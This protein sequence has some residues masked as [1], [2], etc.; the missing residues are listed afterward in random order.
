MRRT[1]APTTA[2]LIALATLSAP[3]SV[4][5]T[6]C[7]A[8]TV[9]TT[10][11]CTTGLHCG[12][13]TN[14]CRLVTC[15]DTP[16]CPGAG[17][18]GARCTTDAECDGLACVGGS[19]RYD[20][21]IDNYRTIQGTCAHPT[22]AEA[23]EPVFS[24]T[25]TYPRLGIEIP[26]LTFSKITEQQTGNV[27]SVTIPWISEYIAAVYR[28]AVP[29][30]AIL[31]TIVIMVAGVLWLTSGATGTL[32]RSQ[33]MITNAVI[34]LLL[35]VGSYVV[36]TLINPD[37]VSFADVRVSI[38]K[39]IPLLGD[40]DE[41]ERVT[42]VAPGAIVPIAGEN[43]RVFARTNQ[44]SAELLPPLQLAATTLKKEGI[45]LWLTSAHRSIED[46]RRAIRDNCVNPPGSATCNPK[47]GKNAACMLQG[48]AESCPHT[49][50]HAVDVWGAINGKQCVSKRA[51]DC[52]VY[53]RIKAAGWDTS[54]DK[55]HTD[56]CQA[57]VIEAMRKAGFCN[58][59]GEAWHFEY[60]KP[61]FSQPCT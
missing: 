7:T 35:L 26:T 41:P 27:I 14:P 52:T 9:G 10:V 8:Y 54:I 55:C 53:T 61:G 18:L 39:P 24:F 22:T 40:D 46:Q 59:A 56:P 3:A 2:I 50:G 45:T 23:Q 30:G 1:L 15:E 51:G 17:S 44:I 12:T 20:P 19:S 49:T 31:A 21:K 16:G 60:P 57:K 25:P 11:Q 13:I 36:L 38:I 5:A 33:E 37:L 42:G 58:W 28:W 43:I 6:T 47:P 48:G 29:V 34:G 32:K 4:A